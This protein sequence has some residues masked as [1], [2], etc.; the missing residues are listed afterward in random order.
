MSLQ[1]CQPGDNQGFPIR[2]QQTLNTEWPSTSIDSIQSTLKSMTEQVDFSISWGNSSGVSN[3][4]ILYTPSVCEVSG[5][6]GL[7]TSTSLQYGNARYTCSNVLSILKNQHSTLSPGDNEVILSFQITNKS[8][9]PSAPDIILMCRPI[10]YGSSPS[11]TSSFFTSLNTVFQG[12]SVSSSVQSVPMQGTLD[13]NT[14][15]GFDSQTLLPIIS[16]QSCL[17]VKLILS[18]GSSQIGSLKVRVNVIQQPIYVSGNP[19]GLGKC[20]N[21]SRYTFINPSSLFTGLNI[22]AIQFKNGS[23][24]DG[25]PSGNNPNLVPQPSSSAICEFTTAV[26]RLAIYVPEAFLGQSLTEIANMKSIQPSATRRKAFKCYRIDPK[27]DIV[28]DQILVDP[29]TGQP[30]KDTMRQEALAAAGGDPS[31]VSPPSGSSGLMPGDIQNILSI[32]VISIVAIFLAV[33]LLYIIQLFIYKKDMNNGFY[34][35]G[36]F[37]FSFICILLL[38]LFFET[39]NES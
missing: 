28:D 22:N 32:L 1:T 29:K 14:L 18:S 17:P 26:Q 33:Y 9:Y 15:Y 20:N 8:D 7:G 21:I 11:N 19:N 30:L 2:L 35:S 31:L 3:V 38:S 24:S 23:G 37:F 12:L 13:L 25:F 16:Y 4:N 34:H 36:L 39:E 10:Q 6:P 5:I 27:K